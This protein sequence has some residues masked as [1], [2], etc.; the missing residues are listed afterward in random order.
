[1]DVNRFVIYYSLGKIVFIDK[2]L[3]GWPAGPCDGK[4]KYLRDSKRNFIPPPPPRDIN[5]LVWAES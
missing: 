1:M 5:S 3:K 2:K 4:C